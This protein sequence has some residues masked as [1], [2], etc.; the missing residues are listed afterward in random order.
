MLLRIKTFAV[1]ISVVIIIFSSQIFTRI[2]IEIPEFRKLENLNDTRDIL[3]VKAVINN[4]FKHMEHYSIDYANWDD[5]AYFIQNRNQSFILSNFPPSQLPDMELNGIVYFDNDRNVVF[6]KSQDIKTGEEIK[7]PFIKP[8]NRNIIENIFISPESVMINKKSISKNGI[9]IIDNKPVIFSISAITESNSHSP[10]FGNVLFWKHF[11]LDTINYIIDTTQLNLMFFWI[12]NDNIKSSKDYISISKISS[13]DEKRLRDN[14]NR[15]N[16]V[17]NGFFNNPILNIVIQKTNHDYDDS[18]FSKNLIAG[19]LTSLLSVFFLFYFTNKNFLKTMNSFLR[20]FESVKE[21]EDYTIKL[22]LKRN[23]ELSDLAESVNMLFQQIDYKNK[24]L[25]ESNIKLQNLSNTDSLTQISNRRFMDSVLAERWEQAASEKKPISFCIC[26]VDYFKLY[27]DNYGHLS[28]DMVLREV[29]RT[30]NDN[31][32]PSTD[33][34]AR[35]GGEEFG[36]ILYNTDS[37]SSCSVAENLIKSIESLE[38]HH[39]KSECS[40]YLTISIGISTALPDIGSDV[41]KLKEEADR[42]LYKAKKAGRN[43]Y[44]HSKIIKT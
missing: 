2:F 1:F 13:F 3:S 21:T 4:M 34:A 42:E 16:I 6:A 18:I 20:H 9:I 32:H 24:Q 26:D 14:D 12:N 17:L 23:D 10:S 31:L 41:E 28:G 5:S 15:I 22:D 38:I 40:K 27:N 8:E 43:R 33:L 39:S 35:Y 11:D 19:I 29:A 25:K 44:S 37:E 36:I 30:M 7:N